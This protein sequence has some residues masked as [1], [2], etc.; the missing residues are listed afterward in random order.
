[1]LLGRF[2]GKDRA[3][4]STL[5]RAFGLDEAWGS[6][7]LGAAP[8]V[9]LD[10]LSA[11]QAQA[12]H[13]ALADVE[14]AGSRFEV[15][16]GLDPG[17][18]KLSWPQPP[19]IRGRLISE[20][21]QPAA[22]GITATL[23]VPCPYTGQRMK[24]TLTISVTKAGEAAV[25]GVAAAVAPIPIAVP[26]PPVPIPQPASQ[27]GRPGASA[28]A[29]PVDAYKPIPTPVFTP[30][31]PFAGR[32]SP[33]AVAPA[34]R[35]RASGAPPAQSAPVRNLTPGAG[36]PAPPVIQGLDDLDELQ[37]M[38]SL[39]APAQITPAAPPAAQTRPPSRILMVPVPLRP[40]SAQQRSQVSRQTG[41]VPARLAPSLAP[42]PDV[43]ILQNQPPAQAAPGAAPLGNPAQAPLPAD[44]MGTPMDLSAFEANLTASGILQAT[45]P[46]PPSEAASAPPAAAPAAPEP[47]ENAPAADDASLWSVFMGRSANPKVHQL[48][49]EVQ[50]MSVAE[51]AKL[52]QKPVVALAKDVSAAEAKAVKQRFAAVSVAVRMTRRT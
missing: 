13:H 4:A 45:P 28:H 25:T 9:M 32:P 20:F 19:R 24:L 22:Q 46:Q 52:C 14:T 41:P 37:P 49:A 39:P 38:E 3:V 17:L 12:V 50:G 10:G 23:L 29:V 51:A 34:P 7:V 18:P 35:A 31:V 2:A 6:Q 5:A 16:P 48:V 40:A 8:I 36:T 42:L 47:A 26:G 15:Q 27:A 33:P 30:A 1:M 44:L 11:E 21:G 43:P